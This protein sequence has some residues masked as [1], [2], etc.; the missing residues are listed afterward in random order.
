[1]TAWR[2]LEGVDVVVFDCDGVLVDS[3]A[4]VDR[5][6]RRWA[7]EYALEPDSV[8]HAAHG[9]PA[10][11][12]VRAWLPADAVE[13]GSLRIDAY[14]L[15]DAAS[16]EAL[17]G[18]I[19]L[20]RRLPPRRWA[21]VTSGTR[22]LFRARLAASGLPEPAITITA[23]DVR[24]G[25]PDPEGYVAAVTRLR[26]AGHRA[27]VVEDT[28]SGIIAARAAGVGTIVRVGT[29]AP[30]D[31]EAA[32]VRDLRGLAWDDGLMVAGGILADR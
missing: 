12:S 27:V 13:E 4:S 16:V 19:D 24:R 25:K 32:V 14:E 30:G 26:V 28:V 21:I 9:R 2:R 1:M 7:L 18:A 6:W 8:V 29:G 15:G 23:D 5:A 17:P 20:L 22:A 31:G 3:L 11:D 10:L